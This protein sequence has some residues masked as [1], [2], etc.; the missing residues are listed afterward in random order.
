MTT[1]DTCHCHREHA[2]A[3]GFLRCKLP[4]LKWITGHGDHAL[5][6]WCGAPTIT[7]WHDANRAAD[8]E[9][10]LHAIRC[11][12]DCRQAHQIVHIDH[13]RKARQ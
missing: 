2:T 12:T 3:K 7:L 4:A 6:A 13:T 1:W 8:A 11:S 10:L 9:N 5:I